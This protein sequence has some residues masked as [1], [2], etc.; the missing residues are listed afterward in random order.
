MLVTLLGQDEYAAYCRVR[1][2]VDGRPS[3]RFSAAEGIATIAQSV[4]QADLFGDSTPIV[5][6]DV[7]KMKNADQEQLAPI[8]GTAIN[9]QQVVAVVLPT[10]TLP[11]HA[12]LRGVLEKGRI[13]RMPKPTPAALTQWLK[14][15]AQQR[16][17]RVEMQALTLLIERLGGN[18]FALINELERLRWLVEPALTMDTIEDVE[19]LNQ[20]DKAFA[21]TDAWVQRRT[22][23]ALTIVRRLWRQQV[24]PVLVVGAFE[25]QARILYLFNRGLGGEQALM[26]EM[27]VVGYAAT[28]MGSAAKKWTLPESRQALQGLQ[29]LDLQLKSGRIDA[30]AGVERW[31]VETSARVG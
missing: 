16:N 24:P 25:R 14:Q 9:S 20:E 8:L 23:A 30:Q 2:L 3:L 4:G 10:D 17:V 1:E 28:K 26:A 7:G 29:E 15:E 11:S 13:E 31:I 27:K 21:A 6:D 22:A 19:P 18:K 5:I 12:S